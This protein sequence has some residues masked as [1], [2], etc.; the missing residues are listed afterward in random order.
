MSIKFTMIRHHHHSSSQR[1]QSSVGG[2]TSGQKKILFYIFM[3]LNLEQIWG[4][5]VTID[6]RMQV[7][8]CKVWIDS[9]KLNEHMQLR[10]RTLQVHRKKLAIEPITGVFWGYMKWVNI[11]YF[12]LIGLPFYH[13]HHIIILVIN[14]KNI[15]FVETFN[16]LKKTLLQGSHCD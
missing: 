16:H 13:H 5:T 10:V 4:Q 3:A 15:D 14:T 9:S 12:N 11:N 8:K 1:L 7:A 2:G 6:S